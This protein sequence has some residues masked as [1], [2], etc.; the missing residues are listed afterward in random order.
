MIITTIIL[1]ELIISLEFYFLLIL[2]LIFIRN[3]RFIP[4]GYLKFD[5]IKETYQINDWD[6][7][8]EFC[9]EF[10]LSNYLKNTEE[11][12]SFLKSKENGWMYLTDHK[13]NM[14]LRLNRKGNKIM[15][16]KCILCY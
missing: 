4:G 16:G 12:K 10:S 14:L 9:T 15:F 2:K 5:T 3:R 8:F 6:W 1:C 7:Y 13:S 11:L